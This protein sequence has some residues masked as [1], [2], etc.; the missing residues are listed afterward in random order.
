MEQ[1][2]RQ[3]EA[4]RKET[5]TAG[6]VLALLALAAPA[7]AGPPASKHVQAS[8]LAEVESL[9]PGHP[10]SVGIRLQ[11]AE[12]WHTYWRNPADSGLPTRMTW[13]LPEGFQAGPLQWPV[14]RR[15]A[16]PP[17]M[18]YGYEGEVLLPVVITPPQTLSPGSEV[19]LAGRVDWL[20]CQEAC[21]PGRAELELVLPVR[22]EA[23]P[24]STRRAA[25]CPCPPG[26][27]T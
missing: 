5:P 7:V 8:L 20:E 9:Q 17:L 15:L 3:L 16:A 11:M 25:F 14:P 23:P 21:I 4:M 26:A 10:F 22:A 2:G 18:S 6:W 27:G 24:S 12:G 1:G 19:R 13:R